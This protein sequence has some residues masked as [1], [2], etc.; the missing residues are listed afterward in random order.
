MSRRDFLTTGA[1][2]LGVATAGWATEGCGKGLV[3]ASNRSAPQLTKY[4]MP[5]GNTPL[6]PGATLDR[7]YD[8]VAMLAALQGIVNRKKPVLYLEGITGVGGIEL[9]AFWWEKMASMG[10]S[11][12]QQTPYQATDLLDLLELYGRE[13]RGLVIW[14][15]NVPATQNIAATLAGVHALLPCAYRP[16]AGTLYS[17]LTKAGWGVGIR[18]LHEDG[19][20]LF[21][22]SGTISGT[23]LPST[24]SAKDDAYLWAKV[25]CLD[26][27]QCNPALM[28]YYVDAYWLQVP[29]NGSTFWANTLVNHDYYVANRGFFFDL[30]PWSDEAPVDDPTQ[31]P[32]TDAKTLQDLLAAANQE[33]KQK[34]MINVGGFVPWQF[35]YTDVGTAGGTHGAVATEWQYAWILSEYNAFMEADAP[36][37]AYIPNASFTQHFPLAQKYPQPAPPTTAQLQTQ[38]LLTQSGTVPPKRFFAFYVGDFDSPAWLY[39]MIPTLW[40]D[41]ARGQVPLSWAFDPNLCLR[42]GPAMA[43]TRAT[44]S[45]MDTFVAGDSGAGY[46]NPGA[47]QTPRTSGLPSGIALWSDHCQ[48]FYDQWDIAVTGFIIDGNAPALNLNDLE[49]YARFSPGGIVGQK[50]PNMTLSKGMPILTMATDLSGTVAQASTQIQNLFTPFASTQFAVARAILQAPSWYKAIADDLSQSGIVVLDLVALMRL[51][52]HHLQ[53]LGIAAEARPSQS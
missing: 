50:V 30:D 16:E 5:Y 23:D 22:G 19:S 13:T 48:R 47:L 31:K 33:T 38:G 21:T 24:G 51:L 52:A 46:L 9:D 12:T 15:P 44:R 27:G 20:S 36:G 45:A 3:P 14:D 42:A 6:L 28:G 2:A 49:A 18:L 35:K 43:W 34:H 32:G 7:A 26:S 11:V 29:Q 25:Q 17:E 1:I 41:S 39:H 37:F 8:E 10:W 4:Q 40:T 53:G